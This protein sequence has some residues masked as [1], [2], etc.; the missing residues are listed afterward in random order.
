MMQSSILKRLKSRHKIFL[1]KI[2]RINFLLS[3]M[4][5]FLNKI[6]KME[7]KTKRSN[8]L[9]QNLKRKWNRK[10]QGFMFMTRT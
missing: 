10:N 3:Y 9:S 6:T 1:K 2:I 8:Y 5:R 4:Y 7:I